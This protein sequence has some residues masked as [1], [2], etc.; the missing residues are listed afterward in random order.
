MKKRFRERWIVNLGLLVMVAVL[1][2]LTLM[3]KE[4]PAEVVTTLHDFIPG[5][6]TEIR[7][8]RSGKHDI[9]F[10]LK[11]DYWHMLAP[12]QARAEHSLIKQILSLTTLPASALPDNPTLKP[13]DFGLQQPVVSIQL[14]QHR[15]SFGDSQPINQQRYLELNKKIMLITDQ[16]MKHLKAGSISY[17][18]RHLVPKGKQLQTLNIADKDI[19]LTQALDMSPAW[20]SI[21]ANWISHA[22]DTQAQQG[23]DVR[24]GLQGDY[25][26]LHYIAEQRGNDIVLTNMQS[27]LEYHLA[28]TAHDS[29]GL[30]FDGAGKPDINSN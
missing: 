20:Q 16:Y 1:L 27:K 24:I 8:M 22:A 28:I 23:I 26:E 3:D 7:I 25:D 17:I 15:I 5:A 11:E 2:S 19:D 29:L 30:G 9:H 6:I 10:Q 18:D 21:K 4:E 14:N 12:Y 13:A